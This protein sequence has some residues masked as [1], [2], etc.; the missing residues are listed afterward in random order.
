MSQSLIYLLSINLRLVSSEGKFS[1]LLLLYLH[2]L[3]LAVIF[4]ED[5]DTIAVFETESE[6]AVVDAAVLVNLP[7]V[8]LWQPIN[9]PSLINKGISAIFAVLELQNTPKAVEILG[10]YENL[11]FVNVIV[12][13]SD[14]NEL[15]FK[16][17][18]LMH[19]RPSIRKLH[20]LKRLNASM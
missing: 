7:T 10:I 9:K 2:M 19:N 17:I 13:F 4:L 15:Q 14:A 18:R 20:V 1:L 5:S 3:I 16:S 6:L 8:S 12:V 11:P